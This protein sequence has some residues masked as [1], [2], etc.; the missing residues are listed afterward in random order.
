M[1]DPS[2]KK[3]YLPTFGVTIEASSQEE[4]I[5]LATEQKDE[6]GDGNS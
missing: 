3:F 2:K 4:A 6:G 5:R 1:A